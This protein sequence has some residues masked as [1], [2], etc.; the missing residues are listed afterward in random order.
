MS[1][2]GITSHALVR[3]W[4]TY[5]SIIITHGQNSQIEWLLVLQKA[6]SPDHRLTPFLRNAFSEFLC[7]RLSK[8]S[9]HLSS[10]GFWSLCYEAV[11]VIEM[12]DTVGDTSGWFGGYAAL[13]KIWQKNERPIIVWNSFLNISFWT[14]VPFLDL[15]GPAWNIRRQ[16]C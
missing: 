5:S 2:A 13:L 1:G 7:H 4:R 3:P 14:T 15:P 6:I 9:F 16:L 10:L 8:V 12:H 11:T